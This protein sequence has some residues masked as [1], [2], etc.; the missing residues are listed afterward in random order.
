MGEEALAVLGP[1]QMFGEMALLDESPRSADARVHERCRV[2]TIAKDGFDDGYL[3]K[4]KITWSENERG[5]GPVG[6]AIRTGKAVVIRNILESPEFT[7]WREDAVRRGY[8]A[9]LG[10]PLKFQS[11]IIGALAIYAFENPDDPLVDHFRGPL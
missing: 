2:L 5:T 11:E 1:G 10:L 6:T 8:A 9:V 4:A 3:E 7:P